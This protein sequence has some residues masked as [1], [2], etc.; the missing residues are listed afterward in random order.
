MRGAKWH[1]S[2][3][4]YG[5]LYTARDCGTDVRAVC[6]Y[7]SLYTLHEALKF[8]VKFYTMTQNFKISRADYGSLRCAEF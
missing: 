2:A 5:A 4:A 8:L 6:F 1:I 7:L 3:L